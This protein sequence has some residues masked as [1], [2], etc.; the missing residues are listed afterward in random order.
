LQ[1]RAVAE[2]L[3]FS[4]EGIRLRASARRLPRSCRAKPRVS[5]RPRGCLSGSIVGA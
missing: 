1:G 2:T 3:D 5:T 4:P